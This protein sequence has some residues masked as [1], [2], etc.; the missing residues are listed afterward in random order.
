[1]KIFLSGGNGFIGRHIQEQ[2]GAKYEILAPSHSELDMTDGPAVYAYLEKHKPEIVLHAATLGGNRKKQFTNIS[3]NNL[4]MFFNI[5]RGKEFFNR[6]FTFGSCVEYD[7]RQPVVE[8]S[9][10]DYK[11]SVPVDEYAFAKYVMARYAEEVDYITHLR[12]F[13]VYGRYED[14][15]TRFISNAMCKAI[16]GMPITMK[17]DVYFDYVYAP[18]VVRQIDFL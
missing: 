9:E 13:G 1:M 15:E 12:F 10:D 3:Y 18:D 6:L 4:Q 2:L 17:Q 7:R 11:K 16:L 8:V 14:Y 5:I